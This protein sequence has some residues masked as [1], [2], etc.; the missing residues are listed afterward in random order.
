MTYKFNPTWYVTG[1]STG[2]IMG[3]AIGSSSSKISD[4]VFNQADLNGDGMKQELIVS[5]RNEQ[6]AYFPDTNGNYVVK[7]DFD[8]SSLTNLETKV[9]AQE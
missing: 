2:I 7:K 1:Y 3:M 4:Y 6:I 9:E 8:F 5:R